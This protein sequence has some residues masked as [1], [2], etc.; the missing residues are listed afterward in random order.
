MMLNGVKIK[1][2]VNLFVTSY[3][4]FAQAKSSCFKHL[5]RV[6]SF[7]SILLQYCV[8]NNAAFIWNIQAKRLSVAGRTR[9]QRTACDRFGDGENKSA[10]FLQP[11]PL[12][13][14]VTVCQEDY[15]Q[16]CTM[17][18]FRAYLHVYY[19]DPSGSNTVRL[20]MIYLH[21]CNCS[22]LCSFH[23]HSRS[24]QY[25]FCAQTNCH[26]IPIDLSPNAVASMSEQRQLSEVPS[27][28]PQSRNQ[29]VNSSTPSN[30]NQTVS[31]SPATALHADVVWV[32][33][34]DAECCNKTFRCFSIPLS[35]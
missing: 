25:H 28:K 12:N 7:L 29:V 20:S 27:R 33:T 13:R 1:S 15:N 9:P 10:L 31:E 22:E 14:I 16:L 26:T 24:L 8:N 11:A 23:M 35:S 4:V 6:F 21:P 19:E 34:T 3:S 18:E 30:L 2:I 32:L 5:H 17:L